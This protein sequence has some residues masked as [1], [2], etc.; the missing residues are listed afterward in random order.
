MSAAPLFA[1]VREVLRDARRPL[2]AGEIEPVLEDIGLILA[3]GELHSC[4]WHLRNRGEVERQLVPSEGRGPKQVWA[5]TWNG[6][7]S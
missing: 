3:T 1:V 4:L 6:E 5:Y 7:P 2:R